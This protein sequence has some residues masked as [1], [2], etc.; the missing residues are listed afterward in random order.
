MYNSYYAA[1]E[2]NWIAG[3]R[4]SCCSSREKRKEEV[5]SDAV[6]GAPTAG[7]PVLVAVHTCV[8][9]VGLCHHAV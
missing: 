5:L 3:L 6:A 7:V 2:R 1:D 4:Q 8:M 9:V